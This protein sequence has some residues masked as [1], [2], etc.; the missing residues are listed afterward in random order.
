MRLARGINRGGLLLSWS[1]VKS[2]YIGGILNA[3]RCGVANEAQAR[4][5]DPAWSEIDDAESELRNDR[6]K[7]ARDT[8]RRSDDAEGRG[9]RGLFVKQ[10]LPV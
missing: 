10:R 9:A 3:F 8:G 1:I 7:T 4:G 2:S 5:S 6:C